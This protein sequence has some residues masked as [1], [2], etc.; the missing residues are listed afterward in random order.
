[1]YSLSRLN[2]DVATSSTVIHSSGTARLGGCTMNYGRFP[3]FSPLPL[4]SFSFLG[5]SFFL[6]VDVRFVCGP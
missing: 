2:N 4:L 1:M 5:F 3:V 6:I